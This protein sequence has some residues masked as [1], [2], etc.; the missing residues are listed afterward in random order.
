M[1]YIL[2]GLVTF[3]SILS[4]SY[5]GDACFNG[6]VNEGYDVASAQRECKGNISDICFNEFL[7]VY[8]V[9]SARNQCRGT[10]NE[11]CFKEFLKEYE[12]FSAKKQCTGNINTACFNGYLK[13]GYDIFTARKQCIQ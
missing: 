6:F 7:K 9:F 11:T 10:V 5:A 12:M 1:K 13:E 4:L 8:D 3:T 2:L